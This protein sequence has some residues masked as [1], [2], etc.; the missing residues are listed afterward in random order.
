MD[1]EMLETTSLLFLRWFSKAYA[2]WSAANP[3]HVPHIGAWASL[4]HLED[5]TRTLQILL[6]SGHPRSGRMYIRLER[7]RL[8]MRAEQEEETKTGGRLKVGETFRPFVLYVCNADAG[9]SA[10]GRGSA[11]LLEHHWSVPPSELQVLA[12]LLYVMEGSKTV[13]TTLLVDHSLRH[14]LYTLSPWLFEELGVR[15]IGNF[16]E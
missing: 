5:L 8:W 6:S 2:R 12:E 11:N 14:F 3:V 16:C 15:T 13:P 7:L 4:P 10:L 9:T 1:S